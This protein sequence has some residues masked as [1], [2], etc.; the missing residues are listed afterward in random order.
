MF[1][2]DLRPYR[3]GPE[4]AAAAS[5]GPEA[6]ERVARQVR[7]TVDSDDADALGLQLAELLDIRIDPPGHV[8]A[9]AAATPWFAGPRTIERVGQT[10]RQDLA[11]A[12]WKIDCGLAVL[13][14]NRSA[15]STLQAIL[16][17]HEAHEVAVILRARRLIRGT[18]RAMTELRQTAIADAGLDDLCRG[19]GI[20]LERAMIEGTRFRFDDLQASGATTARQALQGIVWAQFDGRQPTRLFMVDHEGAGMVDSEFDDVW[21]RADATVGVVHPIELTAELRDEWGRLFADLGFVPLF[22]QLD[23]QC[24]RGESVFPFGD[25]DRS[26]DHVALHRFLLQRG[27]ERYRDTGRFDFPL[28]GSRLEV[29]SSALLHPDRHCLDRIALKQPKGSGLEHDI[30]FS[31][32]VA[33]C[34]ELLE[35]FAPTVLYG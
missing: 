24:L 13:E 6:V 22:P 4:I 16:C 18:A 32:A 3:G 34:I 11:G 1:D 27:W 5:R 12:W 31:E 35:E 26:V 14:R 17:A 28:R 7:A 19:F 9:L 30:V 21:L 15:E 2:F 20:L 25:V 10:L 33:A 8:G 23:R 29:W